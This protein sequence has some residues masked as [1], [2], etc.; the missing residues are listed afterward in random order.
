MAPNPLLAYALSQ[1]A[2]SMSN[3]HLHVPNAN[4]PQLLTRLL[5][6]VSRGV[7]STRGLQEALGVQARTVQYYTQAGQWLGLL[8]YSSTCAL[9]G[10]GLDYV[11][12]GRQRPDVYAKAVWAV[13]FA[14]GLLNG[15]HPEVPDVE[16]VY[17]VILREEP[18][19]SPATARRRA[20]AVR[21]LIAPA[22]GR[23]PR[24]K[25]KEKLEQLALPLG[26]SPNALRPPK[27][28]IGAGKTWNPDV[29]RYLLCALLDYGELSMTHLRAL[30]DRGGAEVIP[31]GGYV[32]MAISRGDGTRQAER[33][34]ATDDGVKR[35]DL[36]ESTLSVVLSDPGYR[37]YLGDAVAAVND[38]AAAIRRDAAV[39]RYIH[40]D[41][42]VFGHPLRPKRVR[43]DLEAVLLD[44]SLDSFPSAGRVGGDRAPV[45]DAFLDVWERE[46][47]SIC[48]PPHLAQLQ[49]GVPAVNR[50]LKQ[51]RQA[52]PVG[53][54]DLSDR[55]VLYHGGILH[56]GEPLPRSVPDTRS[57]RL[58]TLMHAPF[59]ALI[60]AVLLLHRLRPATIRVIRDADGWAIRWDKRRLG[61]LLSLLAGFGRSRGWVVSRRYSGGLDPQT[62]IRS[63]ETVGIVWVN[64]KQVVLEER[65]FE[66]LRNEAEELEVFERLQPLATALE[67]WLE[68]TAQVGQ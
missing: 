9:T 34:V 58:R 51:S 24:P 11:Y 25:R 61:G 29:Y 28:P 47:L 23:A 43:A 64:G 65:F 32:D 49:G 67:G 62:L 14:S 37:V 59:P 15:S 57:L 20:S 12:A 6:M 48:C 19:L 56:P 8:E 13:P 53:L 45:E 41:R 38:R 50:L 40:W 60:A 55:P 54:P 52:Q 5:E 68:Q 46:D 63:M 42:R 31:I 3:R 16:A 36:L 26:R 44:R 30:L 35:R 21:S 22:V 7:R 4:S 1:S 39:H 2:E 18:D 33:V 66:H 27:L 17:A 10:L